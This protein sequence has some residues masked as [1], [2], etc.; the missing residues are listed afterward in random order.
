[1]RGLKRIYTGLFVD[2]RLIQNVM[3]RD[4]NS[5]EDRSVRLTSDTFKRVK[6][7]RHITMHHFSAA[8]QYRNRAGKIPVAQALPSA[9]LSTHK[10]KSG[11]ATLDVDSTQSY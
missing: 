9:W 11:V 2:V 7:K 10:K 8:G 6:M 1:M 3:I 5:E 4:E